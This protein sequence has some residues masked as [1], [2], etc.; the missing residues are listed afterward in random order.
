MWHAS[1]GPAAD[2]QGNVYAITANGGY[3]QDHKNVIHDFNGTADFAEAIVRL[4]YQRT[5]PGQGTLTLDDWFIP[6]RDSDRKVDKNYNYRDQDLGSAAPVLPPDNNLLLG[7]GKDG[8]LYVLD[9]HRLGKKVGDMSVLKSPPVFVTFNGA[10]LPTTVPQIDFPLAPG[11]NP[12]KTH[13]LHGSPAYWNGSNGPM[14]FTWGENESLRAWKLDPDSGKVTFVGRGAEV[15]SA[16]LAA[17]TTTIGGM[18]GG[19]L[20]VSSNGTTPGTGIV[21]ALAPR[22]GDANHDPVEGVARAYDATN[23]D[24]TRPSSA[25]VPAPGQLPG[26]AADH[27]LKTTVLPRC[28][29]FPDYRRIG[30]LPRPARQDAPALPRTR[31]TVTLRPGPDP[32]QHPRR[33]QQALPDL[34]VPGVH[35]RGAGP[36]PDRQDYSEGRDR[37]EDGGLFPESED[38]MLQGH[39]GTLVWM[40]PKRRPTAAEKKNPVA[41]AMR[42]VGIPVAP[43]IDGQSPVKEA[44]YLLRAAAEIEH[45]LL[46]QYLYAAYSSKD[47]GAQGTLV[48]IAKEEM[49][50][51]ISVQNLLMAVGS[52]PYFDRQNFS[53]TPA[54][55][56][57]APFPLVLAP[58]SKGLV[59]D[60]VLAESPM[61]EILQATDGFTSEEQKA[62]QQ[63]L[64]RLQAVGQSTTLQAGN[65]HQVGALY[66][67][68]FWLFKTDD[69]PPPAA[70]WAHYPTQLVLDVQKQAGRPPW[71][72]SD[73]DIVP[74]DK[75]NEFLAVQSANESWGRTDRIFVRGE[76]YQQGQP[77]RAAMRQALSDVAAQGEGWLDQKGSHF[78]QFLGLFDTFA[79]ASPPAAWSVPT[80]PVTSPPP[81]GDAPGLIDDP[82]ALIPLAGA[83]GVASV[84]LD[85]AGATKAAEAL[86]AAIAGASVPRFGSVRCTPGRGGLDW[87]THARLRRV[88]LV[89]FSARPAR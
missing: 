57:P 9:R 82:N 55:G 40:K 10:G 74:G 38:S 81:G 85:A 14:I 31:L 5:G 30:W 15:A 52:G 83:L 37:V 65:I 23:L 4:R 63:T 24:P 25:L 76:L 2:A 51:L 80:N 34:P 36:Q 78:Q 42:K 45:G 75:V 86:V 89:C 19:M 47:D 27:R 66:A 61:K 35:R 54:E 33:F 26:H 29:I 59:A 8:I 11:N 32:G 1:Q 3:I 68:L 67:A 58:L 20:A 53:A 77:D 12:S 71:H 22:D 49:G 13:H 73:T 44:R 18:P 46:V 17:D 41:M 43:G 87:R 48:H 69:A 50:H 70:E 21:W 64:A 6:F 62:N 39:F 56:F 79:G 60:F 16:K 28:S 88:E 72:L 84:R 7:S